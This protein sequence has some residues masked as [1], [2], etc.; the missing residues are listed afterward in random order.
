[1]GSGKKKGGEGYLRGGKKRGWSKH[2]RRI[3]NCITAR[4]EH[5]GAVYR[6]ALSPNGQN[7][8]DLIQK[9]KT[10]A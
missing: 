8:Q 1:V 9:Q 10:G 3:G 6:E 2:G 5:R 7:G 4:R